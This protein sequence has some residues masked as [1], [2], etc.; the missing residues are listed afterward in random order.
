MTHSTKNEA[1]VAAKRAYA[2]PTIVSLA[3][4]NTEMKLGKDKFG[5]ET[6]N[7]PH[8]D[9]SKKSPS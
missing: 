4:H 8:S 6:G 1:P 5:V 2:K 9:A 7:D 3:L